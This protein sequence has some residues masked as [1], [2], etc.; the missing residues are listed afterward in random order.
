MLNIAIVGAGASG[1][2]LM[3]KLACHKDVLICVFEKGKHAGA[4][5]RASG[6]G[7]ANIFNSKIQ[8]DGYNHPAVI[9]K[10]LTR[11]SP[12]ILQTE[13]ENMG[14]SMIEDEEGRMYPSSQFSQTVIN[15]LLNPKPENAHLVT[16]CEVQH[17][18]PVNGLW[19][20]NDC[21]VFF[22]KVILASGS[23]ANMIL[24]NQ[25]NYNAYLTDFNLKLIPQEPSLVGFRTDRCNKLL[26]GCRTKAIVSLYQRQRLIHREIGEVLFKEDGISGIV[27]L[28]MSAY[29]NRLSDRRDC[30]LELNFLYFDEHFDTQNHMRRF[31][32][33]RGLLH[34]K[35]HALYE[36]NPFDIKKYKLPIKGVYDMD[37]AQVCHGG[38]D[39]DEVDANFALNR[40]PG[41]YVAGELLDI[42]GICGGYNLFFAFASALVIATEIEQELKEGRCQTTVSGD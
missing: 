11:V 10:L 30:R 33:F 26:S 32:N 6:G 3:K 15:V 25:R 24:K 23:P 41:I 17:I 8:P 42:D 19:K 1:L 4:K 5:L 2:F 21:P 27:I 36:Q 22:D 7:K 14:L 37:C 16:D 34:P 28:N 31:G 9:K 13:F 40:Y 39:L 12:K 29:Y 18:R 20:I 35:L 38:I